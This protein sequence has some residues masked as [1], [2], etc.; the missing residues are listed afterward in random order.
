MTTTIDN[1]KHAGLKEL[2]TK[3]SNLLNELEQPYVLSIVETNLASFAKLDPE[4]RLK[5]LEEILASEKLSYVQRTD[6]PTGRTSWIRT[7]GKPIDD[8]NH[9]AAKQE[10]R[11]CDSMAIVRRVLVA[12]NITS[13]GENI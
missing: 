13:I 1:I 9:E 10:R 7:D 2:A 11:Y 5:A 4:K 6:V 3:D 8:V 12:E